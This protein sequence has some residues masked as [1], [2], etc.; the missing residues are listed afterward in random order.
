LSVSFQRFVLPADGIVR[1][2]PSSLGALAVGKDPS[3]NLFLP[4]AAHEA[5][6]S[7]LSTM[8]PQ[9][10]YVA[11][12]TSFADGTSVDAWSGHGWREAA[13]HLIRIESRAMAAG[14]C[15]PDG[16]SAAFARVA[17]PQFPA[18]SSV[19]LVLSR[20]GKDI[21]FSATV[22]LVDYGTFEALTGLLAPLP[23]DA[24]AG[25]KGWRLP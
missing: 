10:V 24:D 20:D 13:A 5:F 6:W 8:P 7:G 9:P 12:Q 25:Y 1:Q 19:F 17:T 21:A 15:R 4:V 11:L 18:A 16:S 2:I 22:T 23:L 14:I 3:G